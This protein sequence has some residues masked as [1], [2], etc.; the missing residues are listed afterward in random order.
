MVKKKASQYKKGMGAINQP[1]SLIEKAT[2]KKPIILQEEICRE[3]N[4]I[5]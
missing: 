4:A 5:L 3:A 1:D 2:Q